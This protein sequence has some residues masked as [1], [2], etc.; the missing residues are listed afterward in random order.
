MSVDVQLFA[1]TSC[2]TSMHRLSFFDSVPDFAAA[3]CKCS[4]RNGFHFLNTTEG[5]PTAQNIIKVRDTLV[6]YTNREK[7]EILSYLGVLETLPHPCNKSYKHTDYNICHAPTHVTT[8]SASVAAEELS[9]TK[10]WSK[11]EDQ[12]YARFCNMRPSCDAWGFLNPYLPESGTLHNAPAN[13]RCCSEFVMCPVVHFHVTGRTVDTRLV[14]TYIA[15]ED[16]LF[17]VQA[18]SVQTM[19]KYCGLDSQRC[20]VMG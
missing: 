3:N 8:G 5:I 13:V 11:E 19:R 14:R 15:N 12:W 7:V 10:T 1:P 4:F 20:W 6:H 9:V 2:E 16:S 17:C 18:A